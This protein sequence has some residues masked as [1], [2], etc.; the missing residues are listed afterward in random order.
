METKAGE[1][2]PFEKIS[3]KEMEALRHFIRAEARDEATI[4]VDQKLEQ[5]MR[6]LP[7]ILAESG[8]KLSAQPESLKERVLHGI[9]V[10]VGIALSVT[11]VV[12]A[13]R[14]FNRP[15][16]APEAETPTADGNRVRPVGSQRASASLN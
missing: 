14:Y 8:V 1:L 6:D 2:P 13:Q 7:R 10:V 9:P 12:L 11:G 16:K 15:K 5:V 3:P 4:V